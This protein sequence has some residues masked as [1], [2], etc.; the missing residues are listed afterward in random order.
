MSIGHNVLGVTDVARLSSSQIEAMKGLPVP[1]HGLFYEHLVRCTVLNGCD[2]FKNILRSS[3]RLSMDDFI[4]QVQC[5]LS[6]F[7]ERSEIAL[8]VLKVCDEAILI[9]YRG[10]KHEARP[11]AL[12]VV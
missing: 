10:T 1:R 2:C 4:A 8:H 3:R 9:A 5:E 12:S 6:R 11:M 7:H